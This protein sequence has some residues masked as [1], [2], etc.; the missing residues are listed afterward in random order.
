MLVQTYTC[1]RMN[2]AFFT[3]LPIDENLDWFY[4]L[5][6]VNKDA[7]TLGIKMSTDKISFSLIYT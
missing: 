7:I 2:I 3:H 5:N 4:I 1:K 6:I